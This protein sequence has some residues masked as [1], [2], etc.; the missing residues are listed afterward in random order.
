MSEALLAGPTYD[1]VAQFVDTFEVEE[2]LATRGME[3]LAHYDTCEVEKDPLALV[4]FA[5]A[6][7]GTHAYPSALQTVRRA[8]KLFLRVDNPAYY[9][10]L[11]VLEVQCLRAIPKT[12]AALAAARDAIEECEH[13]A[14]AM[15]H[16]ICGHIHRSIGEY[17]LARREF[18]DADL[19]RKGNRWQHWVELSQAM[20]ERD[21]TGD[22]HAFCAQIN[23]TGEQLR[24]E[25][26]YEGADES[27]ARAYAA[28]LALGYAYQGRFDLVRPYLANAATVKGVSL[29]AFETAQAFEA[30]ANQNFE[31]ALTYFETPSSRLKRMSANELNEMSIARLFVLHFAQYRKQ[32]LH[33]ATQ[34]SDYLSNEA[35]RA[36]VLTAHLLLVSAHFWVGNFRQAAAVLA[37]RVG[38]DSVLVSSQDR[39][40]Y[41]CLKALLLYHENDKELLHA[42]LQANIDVL[43][44]PN[45]AFVVAALCVAHTALLGLLVSS[46]GIVNLSSNLIMLLDAPRYRAM[47]IHASNMIPKSDRQTFQERFSH[48]VV[49]PASVQSSE[50]K[51]VE[52]RLFGGLKILHE[53]K[54]LNLQGWAADTN[55]YLLFVRT[56]LELGGDLARDTLMKLIWESGDPE[57]RKNRYC[58]TGSKVRNRLKSAFETCE[59][60]E[61]FL[62]NKGGGTSINRQICTSDV[63]QFQQ[64]LN[65]ARAEAL[66]RDFACSLRHYQCI[67][68]AYQGHLL[69]GATQAWLK[70]YRKRYQASFSNAMVSAIEACF[71]LGAIDD[72]QFFVDAA[73]RNDCSLETFGLLSMK[74]YR[75]MGR[76]QEALEQYYE[77]EEYLRET[78][79][80]DPTSQMRSLLNELLND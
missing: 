24:R 15:M 54:E 30:C 57:S 4:A 76:R 34:L 55:T 46:L 66:E 17:D 38:D 52:I 33:H 70:T 1:L 19:S 40:L 61:I 80:L 3:E 71:K 72:V 42:H 64:S 75:S 9:D 29:V 50:K 22:Y 39:A 74:A 32:T 25:L 21:S 14:R 23:R 62:V 73:L 13:N 28:E 37:E 56:V 27:I 68:E 58:V 48:I 6:H 44:S 79:G 36:R 59:P 69:P 5:C 67:V 45:T 49:I 35:P 20:V 16:F 47:V 11:S 7:F 10:A 31:V 12:T 65:A 53:G 2:S 8:K 26:S 60:V 77:V 18:R 41:A 43:T 63:M 51:P 78:L